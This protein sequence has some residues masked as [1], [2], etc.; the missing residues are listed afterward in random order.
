MTQKKNYFS[1]LMIVLLILASYNL[2]FLFVFVAFIGAGL[3]LLIKLF[4]TRKKTNKTVR[5]YFI[6]DDEKQID[7]SALENEDSN[8]LIKSS[9][10]PAKPNKPA[11]IENKAINK[12]A[13]NP[14]KNPKKSKSKQ[15]DNANTQTSRSQES[16]N[17]KKNS[18]NKL[19]LKFQ[20]EIHHDYHID[21]S[22][23]KRFE[24]LF[25]DISPQLRKVLWVGSGKYQNMEIMPLS[26]IR[27]SGDIINGYPSDDPSLLIEYL[28]IKEGT[29]EPFMGTLDRFGSYFEFTPRQRYQYLKWL[30]NPRPGLEMQYPYLL[31]QGMERHLIN[32]NLNTAFTW[33]SYILNDLNYQEI[34]GY[35][36]DDTLFAFKKY[37]NTQFMKELI[38]PLELDNFQKSLYKIITNSGFTAEDIR[39]APW[40]IGLDENSIEFQLLSKY[41]SLRMFYIEKAIISL[42]GVNTFKLPSTVKPDIIFSNGFHED[43]RLKG[44]KQFLLANTSEDIEETY[45]LLWAKPLEDNPE[46]RRTL[47]EIM[48]LTA[49]F[50]STEL[51]RRDQK[52]LKRRNAKLKHMYDPLEK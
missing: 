5:K 51:K 13:R 24:Q 48:N 39:S 29:P 8:S 21:M 34:G 30:A 10:K 22:V 7:T 6:N 12:P 32:G 47:A 43:K 16:K 33:I 17:H 25:E 14:D 52:G 18:S 23:N 46:Y 42:Y 37:G 9:E 50:I 44:R 19:K 49:K 4:K 28:P 36:F 31:Y 40:Q 35:L 1:W 15:N 27:I 3:Y 45:R 20:K 41:S 11:Q 26:K 2:W 38:N